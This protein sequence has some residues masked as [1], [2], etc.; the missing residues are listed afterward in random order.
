MCCSS[1]VQP[2]ARRKARSV[3]SNLT[4]TERLLLAYKLPSGAVPPA[5]WKFCRGSKKGMKLFS[6]IC[7]AGNSMNVSSWNDG[8][9][10][11]HGCNGR[12]PDLHERRQEDLLY[13]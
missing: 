10:G 2:S 8:T 3:S 7:R 5:V 1:R 6:P 13:G 4:A 12:C 11:C 9:G